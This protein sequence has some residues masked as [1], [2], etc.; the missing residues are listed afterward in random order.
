MQ[1]PKMFQITIIIT[2]KITELRRSRAMFL[3]VNVFKLKN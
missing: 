1:K 2:Y 3:I